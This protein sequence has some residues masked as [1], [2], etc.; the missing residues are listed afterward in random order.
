MI[1][2]AAASLSSPV[3]Y[4]YIASEIGIV[5][6]DPSIRGKV[7]AEYFPLM[8]CTASA[9]IPVTVVNRVVRSGITASGYTMPTSGI[10]VGVGIGVV[11][12]NGV[13]EGTPVSAPVGIVGTVGAGVAV[14]SPDVSA[15]I[16][17]A[18]G[19][20]GSAAEVESKVGLT[21]V[22]GV[23]VPEATATES[24]LPALLQP[25]NVSAAIMIRINSL[26]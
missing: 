6:V 7:S 15:V 23:G 11:H 10:G 16:F 5:A 26:K 12:R 20:V 2:V 17:S 3:A 24:P 13:G 22:V 8:S 9:G 4:I 18:G 25:A 1:A 14:G 19:S 21:F